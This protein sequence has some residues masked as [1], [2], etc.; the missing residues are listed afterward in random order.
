MTAEL[1]IICLMLMGF[2]AMVA[3]YAVVMV[4]YYKLILHSKMSIRQILNE[5]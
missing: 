4:V 5:I 1:I 3:V 2:G